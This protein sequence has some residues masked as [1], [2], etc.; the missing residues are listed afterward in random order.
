VHDVLYKIPVDATPDLMVIRGGA[1][2]SAARFLPGTNSWGETGWGGPL[3]PPGKV[4]HYVFTLYALDAELDLQPN[5]SKDALLAATAG[6]VLGT[7]TLV[8]TYER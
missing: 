2:D 5:L 8:G 1:V 4:H 7:A 6:H 3:P